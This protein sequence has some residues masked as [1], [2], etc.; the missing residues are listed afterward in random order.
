MLCLGIMLQN[1]TIIFFEADD[2]SHNYIIILLIQVV[3][4]NF[5]TVNQS[6]THNGYV[7][8]ADEQQSGGVSDLVGSILDT[9]PSLDVL[10]LHSVLSLQLLQGTLGAWLTKINYFVLCAV[11]EDKHT[12]KYKLDAHERT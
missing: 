6:L 4:L 7:P 2:P 9:H 5:H 10:H 8:V 12:I 1:F 11:N 3:L